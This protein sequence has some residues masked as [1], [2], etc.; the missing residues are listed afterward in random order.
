[1]S[2]L[3]AVNQTILVT[4]ASVRSISIISEHFD[5][6]YH[7]LP[8]VKPTV[9]ASKAGASQIAHFVWRSLPPKVMH[10]DLR[11]EK[12]PKQHVL[13]E[14][15]LTLK[16]IFVEL[17]YR[18]SKSNKRDFV[19]LKHMGTGNKPAYCAAS[20]FTEANCTMTYG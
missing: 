1:M 4:A 5:L 12:W 17:H 2:Y 14:Q 19:V 8:P 9:S 16:E 13:W 18:K 20:T 6:Q 7:D 10:R 15:S 11:A 3:S